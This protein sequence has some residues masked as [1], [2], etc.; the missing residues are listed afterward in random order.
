MIHDAEVET[1]DVVETVSK[2]ELET[3]QLKRLRWSLCHTYD[4]VQFYRETFDKAG[5]VPGDVNDLGDLAKFPLL[6]KQDMRASY[7]F[8]L[9]AVPMEQVIRVHASSGTTG[10]PV[11]TGHTRQ[12]LRP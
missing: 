8:G 1:Y 7:P 2:D 4:N 11:V 3:L 5:A 10:N 9:F 6:A 12:D